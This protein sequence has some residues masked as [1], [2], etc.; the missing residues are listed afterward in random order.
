MQSSLNNEA[1]VQS[2]STSV[3]NHSETD[4]ASSAAIINAEEKAK[5]DNIALNI[6]ESTNKINSKTNI[7][8][9][10][11]LENV[12]SAYSNFKQKDSL[13]ND[14]NANL[15]GTNLKVLDV[16]NQNCCDEDAHDLVQHNSL[17]QDV[18]ENIV[19]SDSS[20]QESTEV[21]TEELYSSLLYAKSETKEMTKSE[22]SVESLEESSLSSMESKFNEPPK[23]GVDWVEYKAPELLLD[24]SVS[25]DHIFCVDVRNQMYFSRHPQM[26]SLRWIE[27]EQPAEKIAASH[28]ETVVWA[29]YRGTVYSAH[30]K[31]LC[32]WENT[33]W[34]SIARD[35]ISIAVD[36][37][38]GW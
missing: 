23:Y 19:N 31:A 25:S 11:L 14:L 3:Q 34:M 5:L 30:H 38:C 33:E 4:S 29:L 37:E 27:L 24:I 1:N 12:L 16:E 9:D 20:D 18:K 28:S 36:D 26:G 15:P 10:K 13:T 8:T 17:A 22:G 21:D 32:L 2:V 6:C 35:V 7:D